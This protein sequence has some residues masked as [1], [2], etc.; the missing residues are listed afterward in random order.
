MLASWRFA[1]CEHVTGARRLDSGILAPPT[2]EP[3]LVSEVRN[4][5]DGGGEFDGY[6]AERAGALDEYRDD[7]HLAFRVERG[8]VRALEAFERDLM[9]VAARVIRKRLGNSPVD[10][11]D[12]VQTLRERLLLSDG[13]RPALVTRYGGRGS[14]GS[15]LGI[16]SARWALRLLR[17]EGRSPE[18]LDDRVCHTLPTSSDPELEYLKRA[19]R[20]QF[21]QA[22]TT[23]LDSLSPRE[24]AVLRFQLVEDLSPEEIGQIY[25]VHRTTVVRWLDKTRHSLRVATRRHLM[26]NLELTSGEL[27]SVMRLIRS[28][29]PTALRSQLRMESS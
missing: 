18:S 9:P 1:S 22:I 28:E 27:S 11:D 4:D 20:E 5:I 2:T 21:R 3:D 12:A 6:V 25:G 24:H 7:L 8:D 15:W 29:L 23:A 10:V 16:V 19:Y 17:S 13:E 14:L 26:S